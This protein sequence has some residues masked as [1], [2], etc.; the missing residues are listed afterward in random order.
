MCILSS[1]LFAIDFLKRFKAPSQ[2][3][4]RPVGRPRAV[5]TLAAAQSPSSS[6]QQLT[7]GPSHATSTASADVISTPIESS[8][9]ADDTDESPQQKKAKRGHYRSYT[10]QFKKTVVTDII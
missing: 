6:V 9:S 10:V 2:P 5:S 4:K 8:D 1:I 7:S 3:L